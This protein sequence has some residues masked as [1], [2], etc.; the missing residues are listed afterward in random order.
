M[1]AHY[2]RID[3]IEL[4]RLD[5]GMTVIVETMPW[6]SSASMKFSFPL[7]TIGDPAGQEGS[8]VVLYDW[9]ERGAGDLNSVE[10]ANAFNDLGL[11]RGGGVSKEGMTFSASMIVDAYAET[12][13]LHAD[14]LRRPKLL[15]EEFEPSRQL[16]LQ[17]LA[18]L[19]DDP[20]TQMFISLARDFFSSEHGRSS[21]GS[22]EGLEA[23]TADSIIADYQNRMSPNGMIVSVAGGLSFDE[24]IE[25]IELHFGDWQGPEVILPVATTNPPKYSHIVSDSSQTHIGLAFPSVSPNDSSRY[26]ENMALNVLSGGMASRLFSEVR[27][28][29]GLVYSV[30]A[31]RR[32]VKDFGYTMAYA[33]TTP[34]RADETLKVLLAELDRL[35]EGVSGEELERARTGVL[36]SLVMQGESSGARASSSARSTFLLGKPNSLDEVKAVIDAIT[37]DDVNSYL[38]EKTRPKATIMSLGQNELEVEAL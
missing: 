16:A 38:A 26:K 24:V 15:A 28:K 13:A 31:F 1:P 34:E 19:D 18:S 36:S 10:L 3:N 12:V 11:R 29:R 17:E 32:T 6:L 8:S 37:L 7:G 4:A 20:P 25:A 35:H 22:Q 30:S 5:N 9:L 2:E 27:E 33:G 23:L 14:V 21:Y